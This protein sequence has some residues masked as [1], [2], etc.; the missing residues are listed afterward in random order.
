MKRLRGVQGSRGGRVDGGEGSGGAR[1]L[2]KGWRKDE[3]AGAGEGG[4]VEGG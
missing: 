2:A 1:E 4:G 3:G